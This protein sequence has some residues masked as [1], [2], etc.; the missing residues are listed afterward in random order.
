MGK[1]LIEIEG[2]PEL[3]RKLK[4]LP[5]RVKKKHILSILRKQARPYVRTG[6][7]SDIVPKSEKPH[8]VSGKR[9]KKII[10]PGNLRKS[11][12]TITGRRGRAKT[13]PTIYV[14]PR[15]KG[16]H[17]G[18]YG[19]FVDQGTNTGI[20]PNLYMQKIYRSQSGMD[21]KTAEAVA[22]NIQ[23]IIKKIS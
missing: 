12:G 20:K 6:Q 15:A 11:I 10:Q 21:D 9:T 8:I 16:N 7:K 2:F 23:K 22:R 1:E 5:D 4:L 18:W 17:D 14:G 13:N 3:Q 19:H